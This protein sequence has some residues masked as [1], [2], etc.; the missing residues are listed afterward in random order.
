MDA[1]HAQRSLS[2]WVCGRCP[3]TAFTF[4]ESGRCACSASTPLR[5][6]EWTLNTHSV[7]FGKVDA[8]RAQRPLLVQIP[9][10]AST[11]DLHFTCARVP[12]FCSTRGTP[13]G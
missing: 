7:H 11:D 8:V 12:R 6:K 2:T 4:A 5:M 1:V 10:F 9:G 3:R 13:A